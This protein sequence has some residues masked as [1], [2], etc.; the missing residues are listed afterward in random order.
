[1][2]ETHEE[3]R[4]KLKSDRQYRVGAGISFAPEV[5]AAIEKQRGYESRSSFVNRLMSRV[6]EAE[7]VHDGA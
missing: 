6:L 7:P 4:R 1:M 2:P 3:P 5:F